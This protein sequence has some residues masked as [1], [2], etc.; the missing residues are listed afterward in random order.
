LPVTASSTCARSTCPSSTTS[1]GQGT[2]YAGVS[3]AWPP[4][5]ESGPL[6]LRFRTNLYVKAPARRH[7]DMTLRLR[8]LAA[9]LLGYTMLMAWCCIPCRGTSAAWSTTPRT[10]TDSSRSGTSLG[11]R[12][13]WHDPLHLLD[14]N[15]FYPQRWT[16]AYSE[17]N[18]FAAP[19]PSRCIGAPAT[20]TRRELRAG[21]LVRAER[22]GITTCAGGVGDRRR[23]PWAGSSS[24]SAHTSSRTCRNTVAD[25]GGTPLQLLAF[26][27]APRSPDAWPRRHP[28][29]RHGS[30]GLCC[31][32]YSCSCC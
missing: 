24:R 31:A 26:S 18:L 21:A 1:S 23:L 29:T 7:A 13:L 17:L 6:P 15:I 3:G 9:V 20:S 10:A 32:Y 22:T 16:L 27:S 5:R 12:A 8:E 25:D 4:G 30:A 11:T 2:A 14:A 19:S 28:R